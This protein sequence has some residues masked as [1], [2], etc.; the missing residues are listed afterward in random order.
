[1]Y[2]FELDDFNG[3]GGGVKTFITGKT[4]KSIFDPLRNFVY[5]KNRKIEKNF[6]F[7]KNEKVVSNVEVE[8]SNEN[9]EEKRKE[10]S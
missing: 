1:M 7:W 3:G 4:S 6:K 2:F 10:N 8:D 9:E 5:K